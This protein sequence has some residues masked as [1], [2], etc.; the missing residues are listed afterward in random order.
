MNL[1][2]WGGW[3]L[4]ENDQKVYVT[5]APSK[6]IHLTGKER[7]IF[8]LLVVHKGSMVQRM[9]MYSCLYGAKPDNE[10]PEVKIID[11]FVSKFRKKLRSLL[12]DGA[13]DPLTTAW[14]RGYSLRPISDMACD[15]IAA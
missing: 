3:S 7:D 11:V 4:L 13:E 15:V 12:P 14:G 5:A 8:C 1:R 6:K 10:W 9:Q 2:E